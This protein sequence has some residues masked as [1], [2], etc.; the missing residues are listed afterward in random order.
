[1]CLTIEMTSSIKKTVPRFDVIGSTKTAAL[2]LLYY[3]D[4]NFALKKPPTNKSNDAKKKF[5][6]FVLSATFAI[7]PESN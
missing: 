2:S 7:I 5:C 3:G 6:S 4:R 1:M